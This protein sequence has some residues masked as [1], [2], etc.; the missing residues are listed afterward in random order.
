MQIPGL[1]GQILGQTRPDMMR[2]QNQPGAGGG[3]GGGNSDPFGMLSADPFASSQLLNQQSQASLGGG[4]GGAG[5]KGSAPYVVASGGG[6]NY[7]ND[8]TVQPDL[9]YFSTDSMNYS[10]PTAQQ[11]TQQAT[12]PAAPPPNP[13]DTQSYGQTFIGQDQLY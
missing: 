10:Q 12:Q 7:M 6:V 4:S 9:S 13:W 8:G 2:G 3:G 11:P 1:L 5:G